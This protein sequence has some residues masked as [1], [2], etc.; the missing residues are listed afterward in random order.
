VDPFYYLKNNKILLKHIFGEKAHDISKDS[1]SFE[2]L[3]S[4][5]AMKYQT[6]C[7]IESV[8]AG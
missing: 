1:T 2:K 7:K 3:A 4:N 6:L 8:C 5:Q